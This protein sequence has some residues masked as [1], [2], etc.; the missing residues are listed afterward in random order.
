VQ[1]GIEGRAD[2][3]VLAEKLLAAVG[4]PIGALGR[5]IEVGASIGV[6]IG[7]GSDWSVREI[8]ADADRALYQAK[9]AG[10]RRYAVAAP[11]GDRAGAARA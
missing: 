8:T 7:A 9:A 3:G 5:A 6:A 4:A 2:I 11:T 1:T 10:G